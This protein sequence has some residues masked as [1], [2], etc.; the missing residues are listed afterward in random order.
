VGTIAHL[1]M[2]LFNDGAKVQIKH[3][4]YKGAAPAVTDLIGGTLDAMMAVNSTFGSNIKSGRLRL[5]ATTA[6]Q[7]LADFP[8]VPTVEEALKL[9]D[10]E[11][12]AWQ[13]IYAPAGT[14]A[15]ILNRLAA[16]IDAALKQPAVAKRLAELGAIPGGST[17]ARLAQFQQSE[18]DKW[19]KV[20]SDA[21]IKPE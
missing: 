2:E 1:A 7:R 6:R 20:I 21:K 8:E 18:Q 19:G 11:V 4:P 3:I 12:V 17:P 14:P 10:F 9:K 16:E 15:E 13:A 5:L